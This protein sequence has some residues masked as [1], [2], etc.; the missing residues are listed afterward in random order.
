MNFEEFI[1]P[2]EDEQPTEIKDNSTEETPI[3]EALEES[4][5]LDVQ[6]QVVEALAADKAE[7]DEEIKKLRKEN[8]QLKSDVYRLKET[9]AE[10]KNQLDG[11]GEILS[12][13]TELKESNQVAILERLT[14][15]DDKFEG[16]TR[17]HIL[18]ALKEARDAAES[19]GRLRRAQV[20]E[21]VLLANQPHGNLA[22]R[23][24][25]LEKIFKDNQYIVSGT[26]IEQLNKLGLPYKHGE[27]YLLPKEILAR[28]F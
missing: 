26:V 19:S 2:I 27:D 15:V 25:E 11:V 14:E 23:R 17:D 6:K 20:L 21:A 8:Y 9:I 7:Q 12:K 24:E 18:E 5:E 1:R 13:N 4:V 10:L 22:K 3:A 16:E 28:N